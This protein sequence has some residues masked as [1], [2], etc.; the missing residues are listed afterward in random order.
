MDSTLY[1]LA[2]Q[3]ERDPQTLAR[4]HRIATAPGEPRSL[5]R[6]LHWGLLLVAALLLASGLI[7]WIAANWQEQ[8]RMFKLLLIEGALL[9]SAVASLVWRRGRIAALL[10]ATLALGGLLAFI[11]QTYQTGADAWQLFA[12]WAA[13]A[14]LWTLLAR[15]DVLW[16][17][18]VGIAATAIAMWFGHLD[19]WEMLFRGRERFMQQMIYILMWLA[20]ALV[21][22]LVSLVPWT[23]HRDGMAWWSHRAALAM[24]LAAWTTLGVIDLFTRGSSGLAYPLTG[25]LIA[26]AMFVSYQGSLRDFASLCLCTLAANVWILS[27]VA[28]VV[29]EGSKSTASLFVFALATLGCLGATVSGLLA[30]QRGMRVQSVRNASEGALQ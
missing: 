10:C 1:Q 29:F 26:V 25:A 6:H 20:L 3:A 9:A 22:W 18:W 13:L 30:V 17:V 27:L 28:R 8:T 4:L 11:G 19:L 2:A 15:S 21:P 14:L 5:A 23:R 12:T 16:V 24:A 7:F